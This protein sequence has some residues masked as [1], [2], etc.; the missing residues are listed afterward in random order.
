VLAF[1]PPDRRLKL[2]NLF[3]QD[4]IELGSA[5]KLTLGAKIERNDYSGTEFLPNAR[6][7]W[8][9][10][11][12]HLLWGA[13]SRAVRTPSR[14]DRDFY[15]PGA[16]PFAFAGGTDFDSEVAKVFE[17]GYR[18]QPIS[19]LSYSVT[20]YHHDF[21][22]LRSVDSGPAGLT[23]NNNFEGRVNGLAAWGSYRVSDRWRLSAGL[24]RQ[25][26]SFSARPGTAP[27]GGVASLGNDPEYRWRLGSSF[28][29]GAGHEIDISV[30]RMGALPNPVVPAYTA[31][32]VRWAWHARRG[33]ELSVAVRNLS[34][35][36]HA[37]W[38]TP[39]SRAEFE[40]SV[41]FK[42]VWR[43]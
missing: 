13:A 20:L 7:A 32:D 10:A 26:E 15:S 29:I 24:V 3:L 17:L 33:V 28:D 19:A 8:S 43:L 42:A 6:L 30:R 40:R 11:P 5:F 12:N 34:D 1:L 27:V 39:A 31:V 21:E 18:A 37:E 2:L 16:P 4:E 14:V 9:V 41:F 22:R 38:G 23:L 25:R 35:P 36:R